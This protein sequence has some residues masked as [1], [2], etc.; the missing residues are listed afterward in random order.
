MSH[1]TL[2]LPLPLNIKDLKVQKF[3]LDYRLDCITC[4]RFK[5]KTNLPFRSAFHTSCFDAEDS[6]WRRCFEYPESKEIIMDSSNSSENALLQIQTTSLSLQSPW[7]RNGRQ[8][9]PLVTLI[10]HAIRLHWTWLK[11]SWHNIWK[12]NWYSLHVSR[13]KHFTVWPSLP[14]PFPK[15]ESKNRTYPYEKTELK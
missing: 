6:Y 14:S 1:T 7:E 9:R 3:I 12:C 8:F 11:N 15:K 5:K 2:K 10:W 4:T 13:K